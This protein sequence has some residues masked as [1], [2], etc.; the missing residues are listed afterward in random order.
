MTT[1]VMYLL[2]GNAHAARLVVSITSLRKYYSGPI[3]LFTT[4]IASHEVGALC[5]ADPRLRVSHVPAEEAKVRRNSAFLTKLD[6]L[7]EPPYDTTV[8]L[9]ADTLVVNSIDELINVAP[10]DQFHATRFANW[11]TT[12]SI[13][14]KRI[15]RWNSIRQERFDP[16]WLKEIVADTLQERPAINGGVFAIRR[17]AEILSTWRDL[18]YAG[19]KTFICDEIALQLLLH[20]YPHRLLDCRFNCSP[21]HAKGVTDTHIWHFHGEKH[22]T[23]GLAASLW[24]PAFLECLQ[25]N[26][27]QLQAWAPAED[28][29]LEAVLKQTPAFV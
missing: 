6:L 19:W 8:Y 23:P 10:G 24:F 5:A 27:A 11:V 3:T 1:G 15:V 20:R 17:G 22:L 28:P 16:Q 25:Q 12:G 29:A 18:A 4:R 2:T 7:V 9:D 14:K 26:V 13:M 21:R